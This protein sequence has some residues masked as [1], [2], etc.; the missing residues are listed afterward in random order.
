MNDKIIIDTDVGD[1]IDDAFALTLA[2]KAGVDIAGITTVFRNSFQRAQMAKRLLKLCG[3]GDVEVRA[4][5]DLPLVQRI[6]YLR[7]PEMLAKEE[8]DGYYVLPQFMPDMESEEVSGEHAVD[9]IIRKAREFAN[10]LVIVGIAPLTNIALAIRK[11]PDIVKKVKEI[12]LIAG[13]YTKDVPEW[14]IACD[15]EAARIVYTSGIPVKAAGLDVTMQ[16]P[17]SDDELA[18]F[19]EDKNAANE[20]IGVMMDKW[21]EHYKFERPVMHDPLIIADMLAPSVVEY[22]DKNVCVGLWGD[23]R[24]KTILEENDTLE[25][26]RIKVGLAVSPEKFFA[27]FKKYVF[28]K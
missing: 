15:P 26:G 3:R 20:L 11:A 12:R 19:R 10:K 27:V 5:A 28:D 7:P 24:G 6:E 1:D 4:G 16:C 17:L 14:N 8:K 25:S 2:C 21:F 22:E 23:K 18:I 9:F 13:Y